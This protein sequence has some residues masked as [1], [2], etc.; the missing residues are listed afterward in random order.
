MKHKHKRHF[1]LSTLL[2][3]TLIGA[4]SFSPL[5]AQT[6]V[7]AAPVLQVVDTVPLAGEELS[8]RTPIT[9]YFD[10]ELDCKTV[11]DAASIS[12]ALAGEFSCEGTALTFTPA[13]EFDRAV[14]YTL[15]LDDSLRGADGA[16]LL[17]TYTL[18]LVTAGFLNVISTLPTDGSGE[19]VADT[20]LTVIFNRP[21]VPLG[22]PSDAPDLPDPL[23]IDP[24]IEGTGAWLNTA[25]YTFKPEVAWAGGS[26]YTVTVDD[27]TAVD[28]SIMQAP[29]TFTF[30]VA[31][32]KVLN[33]V[34]ETAADKI[35]LNAPVQVTFNQP[36]DAAS[37]EANF[38]LRP[39]GQTT[40]VSGEFVWADDDTGFS[41]TPAAN[42]Q[43]AT[44][45]DFGY[46]AGV[47]KVKGGGA[48]LPALNSTFMT[49]PLP[50]IIST[51]PADGDFAPPYGGFEL[52]FASPMNPETLADKI[53]ID[54]APAID[55]DFFYR[56]WSDS[57]A[58]TFSAEPATT[59][60]I[61]IAPGMEDQYG[62]AIQTPFTFSYTTRDYDAELEL[63]VPGGPVGFYDA[64][65]DTTG[66]FMTH[67]NVSGVNLQLYTVPLL[68][69]ISVLGL[70]E[71]Y[72]LTGNY[73]PRSENL[74]RNWTVPNV[75]PR[76]VLRYDFLDL[77]DDSGD[78][79]ATNLITS[80]GDCSGAIAQRAKVGDRATVITEPEPLRARA[81][82]PDGEVTE[83]L[84]KGYAFQIVEGP[85]CANNIRW[86]GIEL[87]DGRTAW[88]AEGLNDE[89][90]FDITL[91]GTNVPTPQPR[92]TL[93]L[94]GD[95]LPPGIYLLAASAPEVQYYGFSEQRHFMVVGTANLVV[96]AGIDEVTVWAT[97]V[98]SGRPLAGVPISLYGVSDVTI[99]QNTD[100]SGIARF[101]IPRR[102]DL[103][104]ALTAVL[105]DGRNFGVGFT[106][107][108]DGIDPWRFS[109]GY[110][111]YPQQY[112]TYLYTERPV[113]RPGQ[114]VYY[115][116]V[117]RQ[118]D[119]VTYTLPP[120]ESVPVKIFDSNGNLIYDESVPLTEFGTFSGIF[121]LSEDS[122]LGYHSINVELPS[123]NSFNF[124]GGTIG[125][126]VA[127]YRL[128]EYQVEVT[129]AEPE[130]VQNDTIEV[131]VDSTFFFGGPVIDAEVEY[132]VYSSGYF[133]DYKGT[134]N[135]SFY[136]FTRDDGSSGRLPYSYMYDPFYGENIAN[137][138]GTTDGNGD[139]VIEVPAALL[140]KEISSTWRIEATVHDNT[141][142]SVSG[143]TTVVVHSSTIYAGVA[144]ERYIGV[145]GDAQ[146]ANIITVD[147]D[148]QPVA[149]QQVQVEVVERRWSSVQKLD[150]ASGRITYEYEVEEIPLAEGTVT[151]GADGRA[152]F[153]FVPEVGGVYKVKVTTTDADG[154]TSAASTTM[155]VSG[156]A[157]E[158]V[159]WR[160]DNDN[161]IEL[162]ADKDSYEIGETATIL[163]TSP[164]QGATEALVTVER[165]GVL[166]TERVSMTGNSLTYELPITEDY[167]PN[168][169]F[170]VFLVKGVD[171]SNPVATFRMGMVGLQVNNERKELLIDI[172]PDTDLAGPGDTVT[173]TVSTT[174]YKG[175]PVAAEV[176]VV[177]TDL[178]SLSI[179]QP[180]S[181]P[182]LD[183]FYSIQGLGIRTASPLTIN[184]D[185]ITQFVLDVIKG[186]G[187]GGG[188]GGIF[189]IREE[190]LDTAYWNATLTTDA[191]GQAT[192]EV[193][194]PDN[195][196][197]WRLDARGVT[198]GD[199]AT[200]G[201][202]LVGQKTF[203]LLSTKPL[204]V[205]PVTPRFMVVG[206]EIVLAA[207]VNNNT[208][209]DQVVE[210][211]IDALGV[212]LADDAV[213]TVNIPAGNNQRVEWHVTV[214]DVENVELIFYANAGDGEFTDATRPVIGQGA[215]KL[216]PVYRYEAPET[217]G[218][219]GV[220][221]QADTR[222]EKIV[223]PTRFTVSEAE[224]T[225]NLSSSLAAS[226]IKTLDALENNDNQS[227]EATI[228]RFLPNVST[229]RAL[230]QLNQADPNLKA[231]LDGLVNFALQRLASQQKPDGG[232]GWYLRDESNDLVTAWA[233]IGLVEAR[234]AGFT[235]DQTIIQRGI[236]FLESRVTLRNS[237][238]GN[239]G[240]YTRDR[241]VFMLYALSRA[242]APDNAA[243]SNMYDQRDLLSIYSKALLALAL[244]SSD[245]TRIN[246]L[247]DDVLAD[248]II[249]AN[250]AHWEEISRDPFNWNSDTRTT[251]IV[252][253]ALATYR[254]TNEL[255][256]NVVRWLMVARQG[257]TWET[258]QET[259]WSILGL[260][261]WM[262][263][264]GELEPAYEYLLTVNG[265]TL[266]DNAATADAV[267][268]TQTVEIPAEQ[269]NTLE[270]NRTEGNG[271]L[272]YTAYLRAMLPVPEIEPINR[273]IIVQRQYEL[274]GE[275]VTSAAVGDVVQVRLTIIA[276]NDLYYVV[277][278]DPLPAGAEGINPGLETSQQIGTQPRLDNSNPLSQGWGWWWFSTTE[279]YD[280][281]VTLSATYLPA[282]TYEYV[283]SIRPSVEGTYNVI[284]PTAREF[285]F[286]EVYGRG[287]G[288]IFTVTSD[289]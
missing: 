227:I 277:V 179:G 11:A 2:L 190:F 280:E 30:T 254:P 132:Y 172:Q 91:A 228:S 57:Y 175:D 17:E 63:K 73:A 195:L 140:N 22:T 158:Y 198:K 110:N 264:S 267:L 204:L 84:Y 12:P 274:N 287:A 101:E 26:T 265:E 6:D 206:D 109:V 52:Y 174:D 286:P 99:A 102:S 135:Y 97:D 108:S 219:G 161:R 194:L 96:K 225:V 155:W 94:E 85:V 103:Y 221:R 186:G 258:T 252:L 86:W 29:Y 28:G 40:G 51:Y 201:V 166:K 113:Y 111:Y 241:Q 188:G 151:T 117:V 81:F 203:D 144:T 171:A 76:N 149:N 248:A 136:D 134:G 67:R 121:T 210:V 47:V 133:F 205:R 242:G 192:F 90:F 229:Y 169:Y 237:G 14:T 65:R 93:Q 207:V 184:T 214:D 153:E 115:R 130:V 150:N 87:R 189:E 215:N 222:V 170:S 239:A 200:N 159:S 13:A 131:T 1:I 148:S 79:I 209:A 114:P 183:A 68:D 233:V 98:R 260:T 75:A 279:F 282:G 39:A 272:Y 262:T 7:P 165:G 78:S 261:D 244:P 220:L 54:P 147:W 249:S 163:I 154:N 123:A 263:A 202:M 208:H 234:D 55:P 77:A 266:V 119:D 253:K 128:P 213:Q 92:S 46:P 5:V 59:Y 126:E 250:G 122:S 281:K 223:L 139:F 62:N 238:G 173:Y 82:P 236:N 245:T 191:N 37:L 89:Y 230:V 10:R 156:A 217:T 72:N 235:V 16:Q 232:W 58:I 36:I 187:G 80:S 283:Y 129:P 216:L 275:P 176:G 197:T 3:L 181:G 168:V 66:L 38:Y 138:T 27:V 246:A 276:P 196:T 25:I 116:G 226:T 143:R 120:F 137:G 50:A 212:T 157:N 112:T 185:Y 60:T 162:I 31:L 48:T 152:T 127:E 8:A 42:L 142:Q 288:S 41:F 199:A 278:N 125:F 24:P 83:L 53:T 247:L 43:L 146:Q 224:I 4:F 145:A 240:R 211:S 289:E 100:F 32:P 71:Y 284:P 182:I 231:E 70:D 34:P 49:V 104:T 105:D 160:I 64:G 257:D 23:T 285:Y 33:T 61:T 69:F 20:T 243:M 35:R 74:L 45:Y 106:E 270:F 256:P 95:T 177:L 18:E 56:D 178:A 271:A 19:A 273:G 107:W 15:T 9:L 164:F 268:D 259:A 218:T 88:V 124:E 21:V 44:Q 167:A 251:A 141:G 269:Q 118:R 180:N 193:T 255:V